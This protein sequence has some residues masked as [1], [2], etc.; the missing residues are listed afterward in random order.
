MRIYKKKSYGILKIKQP[1]E[2]AVVEWY[3]SIVDCINY[4]IAITV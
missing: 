3:T 2:Q 1:Y 4:C